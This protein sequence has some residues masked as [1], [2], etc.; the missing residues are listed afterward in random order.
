MATQA[1]LATI[2]RAAVAWWTAHRPAYWSLEQH[3]AKPLKV[4]FGPHPSFR[5]PWE[6][7]LAEAV[8]ASLRP[9]SGPRHY[10]MEGP[11]PRPGTHAAK[12]LRKGATR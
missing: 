1:Q 4:G 12:R 9:P 2:A 7:A 6:R 11:K 8:A 5:M 3:L 10:R